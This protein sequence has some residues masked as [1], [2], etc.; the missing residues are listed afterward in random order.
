MKKN[1]IYLSAAALLSFGCTTERGIE[2]VG[3]TLDKVPMTFSA[4]FAPSRTTLSDTNNVLWSENDAISVFGTADTDN[5]SFALSSGSGTQSATFSGTITAG[6]TSYWAVY[7][8]S[9]SNSFDASTQTL[10]IVLPQNQDYSADSFSTMTNPMAATS[11]GSTLAFKNLCG[12]IRLPLTGNS[13][14]SQIIVYDA[15]GMPLAGSANVTFTDGTPTVTMTETNSLPVVIDCGTAGVTLTSTATTFYAVV[16]PRSFGS[17]FQV[18]IIDTDNNAMVANIAATSVS[19]A[20]VR[21]LSAI[22]YTLEA[23][24]Y[25]GTSNCYQYVTSSSSQAQSIDV[26]PYQTTAYALYTSTAADNSLSA[27]T[28]AIIWQDNTSLLTDVTMS[29]NTLSFTVG[30]SQTG[31]ALI[32]I[33][34]SST[35]VWSFHIWVTSTAVENDLYSSGYTLMDRNLGATNAT[36]SPGLYYQ[37]GRKEP[38]RNTTNTTVAGP[39]SVAYSVANPTSFITAN[40]AGSWYDDDYISLWGNPFGYTALPEQVYTGKKTVFDPCPAGY[41][42][43]APVVFSTFS[44]SN[45]TWSSNGSGSSL[46]SGGRGILRQVFSPLLR[47]ASAATTRQATTGQIRLSTTTTIRVR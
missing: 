23:V 5:N 11:N 4:N 45:L 10:T 22:D 19:R 6:S 16:P 47:E 17:G 27:D 2:P 46:T 33:Y 24:T 18:V 3:T 40:G 14:I 39:Q 15:S 31:N 34:Q 43:A 8:Y 12:I 21:T 42:V 13:T 1:F 29:S 44:S 41:Q 26:S 9:A 32:G 25:Y 30:A 20:G 37:W 38:F 7:P 28:A 36:G 35:V